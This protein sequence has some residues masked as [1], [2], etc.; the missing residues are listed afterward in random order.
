M[1]SSICLCSASSS[2]VLLKGHTCA[3]YRHVLHYKDW[4]L[5]RISFLEKWIFYEKI[6]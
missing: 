6:L 4:I 1:Y 5:F 2:L 3:T